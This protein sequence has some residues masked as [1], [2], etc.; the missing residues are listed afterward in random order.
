MTSLLPTASSK[1]AVERKVLSSSP[2]LPVLG[3]VGTAKSCF[4]QGRFR[5]DISKYIP[6][7]K[8][9]ETLEQTSLRS[10]QGPLPVSVEEVFGQFP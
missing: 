9:G 5:L 1:G 2:W 4:H 7:L 8:G 6:Y 3:Q 10:D